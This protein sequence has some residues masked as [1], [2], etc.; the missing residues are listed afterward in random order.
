MLEE[1]KSSLHA[2]VR[3]SLPA[4][5]NFLT[6][7]LR[8]SGSHN[9]SEFPPLSAHPLASQFHH[10]LYLAAAPATALLQHSLAALTTLAKAPASAPS[11]PPLG[12]SPIHETA[13]AAT[14]AIA[15][16]PTSCPSMPVSSSVVRRLLS[17]SNSSI[18]PH[19]SPPGRPAGS[20]PSPAVLSRHALRSPPRH[21][22]PTFAASTANL[23]LDQHLSARPFFSSRGS[24]GGGAEKVDVASSTLAD[25]A[26]KAAGGPAG[27]AAAAAESLN[28]ENVQK[29]FQQL[30]TSEVANAILNLEMAAREM[31]VDASSALLTSP[32]MR[33]PLVAAPVLWGVRKTAHKHFCA[34]E[35]LEEAVATLDRMQQLGL[36]G[37]LDFSVEDA[38]DDATCDRNME[39]FLRTIRM[40]SQ[41]SPP[42][43]SFACV[44][45]TALCPLPVLERVSELLRWDHKLSSSSSSSTSSAPTSSSS[46]SV[47]M[48][49]RRPSLPILAPESPTYFTPSSAPSPLTPSEEAAITSA[50]NRLRKI[51]DACTE[52]KL[53]LLIDA[54]YQSVEPAIDY[55]AYAL[56]MEYNKT[57]VTVTGGG[58]EGSKTEAELP[59]VYSTVQCY[60]RD[61]KPRLAA[62]FGAAQEAGVGF[63][64]KLVRGAYLVRESAEAKKRGATS[65]VHESIEN[66][67]KCYDACAGMM[68]DAAGAAA[69]RESEGESGPAA[70][71]VLA[72]HNYGSGRVAVMRAGDVGLARTDPRLHFAQLK[73]M[74]DG[75]SLGL[76]FAGF[77]ASKYLPYGPVRDVMPYLLRRAHENRG[78][79]GNTR[80]ERQWLRAELMRRIR[81]V[82]GA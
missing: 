7:D 82:F 55:L 24:S 34:G 8:Y 2:S 51:C 30:S 37:I 10:H 25:A 54:E 16:G 73:G 19:H 9:L 57:G 63:G 27:D 64:V 71:V 67:H 60:L 11:A 6:P 52:G 38:L 75:L 18:H 59:L 74:A 49:W 43:V 20:F 72:T 17:T 80:D 48:P 26:R 45:I 3:S 46:A 33:I 31:V 28:V 58:K 44:K 56:M 76:G 36:K 13:T 81:S 69:K 78:V 39:G 35:T 41:L 79:L 66:T 23:V 42:M 12:T 4:T 61:A 68:I 29:L 47:P 53:P 62:S 65:P 15:G 32:V 77:N 21:L 50:H 14:A 1:H 70:G 22:S 40:A 5:L